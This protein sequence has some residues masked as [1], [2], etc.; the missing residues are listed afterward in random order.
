M[1]KQKVRRKKET[2]PKQN[3]RSRSER[4][5][6][7]KLRLVTGNTGRLPELNKTAATGKRTQTVSKILIGE[8]RIRW[9]VAALCTVVILLL[10]ACS[11]YYVL[12]RYRVTTVYVE[13]SIHYT[14]EQIMDMVM[15]G[16]LGHNSLYLSFKYKD[17]GVDNV[18]CVQS[19]DVDILARDTIK[20][21]VYEK[22]L[23]GYIEY[24]G[25]YM[26]FDKD[27][28]VVETSEQRT[29]GIPQ[30]TGLQ[31]GYVVM[32]EKLPVENEEVFEDIL[33]ITQ[34]LNK[35]GIQADRIYFDKF[36]EKTLYFGDA[37]VKLGSNKDI[38]EKIMKLKP[39]LPGLEGKKGTLRMDNYTE[40]M[41]DFTF[42]LD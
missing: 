41:T 26:Y 31:F 17:K 20:I 18:P 25:R 12:D 22:A 6:N 4:L 40:G 10:C 14:N 33:D 8:G 28:I 15:N 9:I 30:V 13:G 36:M 19:M 1:K 23:A 24:L 2:K 29:P 21:T 35:Y 37:K 7:T 34:R 32:N 16:R 38:D 42:E 39:I 5:N 27:G 3:N 11:V